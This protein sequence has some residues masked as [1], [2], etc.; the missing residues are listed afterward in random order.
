MKLKMRGWRRS[1]IRTGLRPKLPAN[2]EFYR[3]YCDFRP[4][5]GDFLARNCCPAAILMQFPSQIN[6]DEICKNREIWSGNREIH[7]YTKDGQDLA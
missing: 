3:E 7:H 5:S 4:V 6:R 2:R 1:G